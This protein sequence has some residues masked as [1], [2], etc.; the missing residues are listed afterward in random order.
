MDSDLY[1]T[2]KLVQSLTDWLH[3]SIGVPWVA[4]FIKMA[5]AAVI[6]VGFVS[7]LAMVLIY[8]ERKVAGHMQQRLG[9]MR[10]GPHGILQTLADTLKLL[11]KEEINPKD[12]DLFIY[13]LAPLITFVASFVCLSF[14]PFAPNLQAVRFNVGLLLVLGIS[15]M[16]V[17]GILAA[18]WSSNNKWSLLGAMR[19]GAQIISYELSAALALLTMVVFAG[20]LDFHDI[21]ESQRA[22]WWIWRAPVVGLAAFVVYTIA[23]TAECNRTPFDIVEGESE[24]TSGFHT[25]Y[26]S[27]K[28]A[29]FFLAEFVNMFIVSAI[30]A[31][32]FLGGWMPFHLG[33]WQAFNQVCD[34]IPTW[35]WF[36]GKVSALIFLIMWFRWT[37]PRLRVDQLMHFEWKFLMPMSFT[38][39][40]AAAVLVTLGWYFF[41]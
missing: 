7:I 32:V 30:S 11:A 17:L 37:F 29:M 41:H 6:L 23:A 20:S 3:Q 9:P 36:F 33:D 31:T 40:A 16:G 19:A 10:V 1:Q 38:N 5:G 26:A 8:V 18:G 34:L 39:L 35:I 22:G 27:M 24:L 21:V 14:V 12:A 15:S 4:E 13:N 25:E 2:E 28:F